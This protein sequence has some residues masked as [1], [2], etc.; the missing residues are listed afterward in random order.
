MVIIR[1][2][3]LLV[4]AA[5]SL[6]AQD[7]RVQASVDSAS[8]RIGDWIEVRVEAEM[9]EGSVIAGPGTGDSL[10]RFEVLST[11]AGEQRVE[12]GRLRQSFVVRL[13]TFEPGDTVIPAIPFH[14]TSS[15][16]GIVAATQPIPVTITTI[17]MAEE[18]ELKD[19]KPP[20]SADWTFEDVIPWLVLAGV[21]AVLGL[22]W[23]YFIRKKEKAK[24]GPVSARPVLPAHEL[25]LMA[26]REV[27]DKRLW[28]QGKVKQYYSEV[29]EIIRRFFEARFGIIA[30]E[31][32]SDEILDRL[33][34]IPAAQAELKSINTLLLTADLVKFAKYEPTMAEHE[35]ELQIAYSIVRALALKPEPA[36]AAGTEVRNHVR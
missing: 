8:Y 25:A 28:Q 30:L 17:E 23:W 27:E 2:C 32:T 36:P 11:T 22:G 10:G 24:A 18:A 34:G 15:A 26:L 4:F 3:M 21:V 9:P 7:V 33:K 35:A 14:G 13:T 19:I 6:Q 12:N 20:L 5:L 16:D 29:T 31:L 1:A